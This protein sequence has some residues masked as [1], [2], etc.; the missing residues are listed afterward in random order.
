ME[1]EQPGPQ[2]RRGVLTGL[3]ENV[4]IYEDTQALEEIRKQPGD[5][6][7]LAELLGICG[8]QIVQKHEN[9][10]THITVLSAQ[11]RD[12][13]LVRYVLNVRMPLEVRVS[14]KTT[15]A[16][17]HVNMFRV[18]SIETYYEE[19]TMNMELRVDS[20]ICP[21]DIRDMQLSNIT[22]TL[23]PSPF[24][25]VISEKQRDEETRGTNKRL[26]RG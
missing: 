16:L 10:R 25:H 19:Q 13:P 4:Y 6:A 8:Q 11:Y 24:E 23:G 2:L 9:V 22:Y 20:N 26:R 17:K 3:P 1:P 12:Q 5:E 15:T 18:R 21:L 14:D 7:M